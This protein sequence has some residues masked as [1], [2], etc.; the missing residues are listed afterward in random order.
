VRCG[1]VIGQSIFDPAAANEATIVHLILSLLEFS[2]CAS[3]LRRRCELRVPPDYC[4]VPP[5]ATEEGDRRRVVAVVVVSPKH[6]IAEVLA[7]AAVPSRLLPHIIIIH[8]SSSKAVLSSF[9][10]T[11]V[12]STPLALRHPL[13]V[14]AHTYGKA[15][16]AI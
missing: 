10:A 15:A 1:A 14:L 16:L 2:L 5:E 6:F 9:V 13:P 7:P 3:A 12:H 11:L 4:L 8:T